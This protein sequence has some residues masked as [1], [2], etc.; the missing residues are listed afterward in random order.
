MASV[1]KVY[2]R[3]LGGLFEGPGGSGGLRVALEDHVGIP[4]STRGMP[5]G[6]LGFRGIPGILRRSLWD[7][8]RPR[9]SLGDPRRTPRGSLGDHRGILYH[10]VLVIA[11]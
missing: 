9:G 7:S 6:S 8:D 5:R 10:K 4:E 11:V 1:L 2:M 3:R